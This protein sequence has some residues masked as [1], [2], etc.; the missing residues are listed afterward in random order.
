MLRKMEC[1]GILSFVSSSPQAAVWRQSLFSHIWPKVEM[2]AKKVY[3]NYLLL[4]KS[5]V[6]ISKFMP[7]SHCATVKLKD[8]IKD[9]VGRS[10]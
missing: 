10:R 1:S 8:I 9:T 3:I 2:N 5:S 4:Y 6:G 7:N